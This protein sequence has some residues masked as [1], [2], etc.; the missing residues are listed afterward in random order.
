MFLVSDDDYPFYGVQF[1]PEKP[2]FAWAVNTTIKHDPVSV[3]VSQYFANFFVN[4]G[5]NSFETILVHI[6]MAAIIVLYYISSLE[7]CL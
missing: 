1:H 6:Y 2:I 5:K 4:E 7:G 3:M